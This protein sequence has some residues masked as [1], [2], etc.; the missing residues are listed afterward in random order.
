M[1]KRAIRKLYLGFIQIYI[2]Y[3]AKVE[4]FYGLCMIEEL[5]DHGYD[6]SPG[7]LYPIL[8]NMEK[9]GL[10]EK[11][12]KVESGRARKY[13]HTTELG[14]EALQEGKEKAKE[15]FSEISKEE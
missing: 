4:P 9:D 10:L 6:I 8:H 5:K 13:Y 2:L 12:E 15:L 14:D 11:H 1:K 3:H 7:T